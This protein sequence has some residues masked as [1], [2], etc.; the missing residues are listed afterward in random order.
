VSCLRFTVPLLRF[1]IPIDRLQAAKPANAKGRAQTILMQE[2]SNIPLQTLL[3]LVRIETPLE[4]ILP[5][6]PKPSHALKKRT[7]RTPKA[8]SARPRPPSSRRKKK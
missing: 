6:K 3:R 1:V 5:S 4:D 8:S 2:P 7:T